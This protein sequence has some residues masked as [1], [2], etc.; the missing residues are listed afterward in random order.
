[1][2]DSVYCPMIDGVIDIS[3]CIENVDVVDGLIVESSLPQVYKQKA[4][5]KDICK[6]CK[7]HNC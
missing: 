6:K 4:N 1:M 2:E 7:Y 5:W 3:D